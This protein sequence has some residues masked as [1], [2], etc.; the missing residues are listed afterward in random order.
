MGWLANDAQMETFLENKPEEE[1]RLMKHM[2]I[3]QYEVE[4]LIDEIMSRIESRDFLG[5]SCK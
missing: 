5:N 4:F 3:W 1:V 2:N